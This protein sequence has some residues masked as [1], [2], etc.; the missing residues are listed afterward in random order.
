MTLKDE[1]H[2]VHAK[3]NYHAQKGQLAF[4]SGILLCYRPVMPG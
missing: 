2:I 3:L 1:A 4:N